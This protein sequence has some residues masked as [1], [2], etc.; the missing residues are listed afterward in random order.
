MLSLL[1]CGSRGSARSAGGRTGYLQDFSWTI[2]VQEF[3]VCAFDVRA[4]LAVTTIVYKK[5]FRANNSR[6]VKNPEKLI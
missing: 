1:R 6:E 4:V 3:V 5:H 2:C